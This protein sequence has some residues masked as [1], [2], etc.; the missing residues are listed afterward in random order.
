MG[1]FAYDFDHSK[2]DDS[3]LI[4]ELRRQDVLPNAI[5]ILNEGIIMIDNNKMKLKYA[6]NA[7]GGMY[8]LPIFM[9]ILKR[10]LGMPSS[11]SVREYPYYIDYVINRKMIHF[12]PIK[13][14]I[15]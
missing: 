10:T 14:I 2:L 5:C 1:I 12:D 8:A 13:D 15:A 3:D 6:H 9:D 11:S 4:E 7:K